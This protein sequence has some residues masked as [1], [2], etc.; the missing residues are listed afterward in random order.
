ML[1]N[2]E[3]LIGEVKIGGSLGYSDPCLV[4]FSILRGMR[5]VKRRVRSLDLKRTNI[6]LVRVLEIPCETAL[7]GK[8]VNEIQETPKDTF[9]RA[10]ER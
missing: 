8:G 7:G 6:C 2:A 4:E 3:E 10:Q 9:L 1:R 5:W